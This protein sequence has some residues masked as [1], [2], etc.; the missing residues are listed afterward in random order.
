MLFYGIPRIF[1]LYDGGQNITAVGKRSTRSKPATCGEL[2]RLNSL[3]SYETT[4][5]LMLHIYAQHR[6]KPTAR[7]GVKLHSCTHVPYPHRGCIIIP[8]NGEASRPARTSFNSAAVKRAISTSRRHSQAG[9]LAP[10]RPRQNIT[11]LALH[12]GKYS[13]NST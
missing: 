4:Y 6:L 7:T 9:Y 8:S 3:M 1:H 12:H 10:G 13:K 5:K 11:V 2:Y